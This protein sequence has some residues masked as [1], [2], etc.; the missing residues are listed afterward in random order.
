VSTWTNW[1][2]VVTC[3]PLRVERPRNTDELVAAVRAAPRLRVAGSGHS[4]SEVAATD[5]VLLS[6]EDYATPWSLD[7]GTGTATVPGG[8][9][10]DRVNRFLHE[11]GRALA[12][13]GDIDRQTVAGAVS[14]GTHGTGLGP[15]SLSAQ[16]DG[17]TLVTA[18]GDVLECA[19]DGD[20]DVLRAAQVGLGALGVVAEVRLRTVPAFALRYRKWRATLDE[21]V[22]DLPRRARE[23]R[24][25]EFFWLPGADVVEMKALDATE[26]A[27]RGRRARN[28]DNLLAENAG[29]GLLCALGRRW[30]ARVPDL[31]RRAARLIRE[32][33]GVDWSHRVF[34]SRRWVHFHEMEYAVPLAALPEVVGE[35]RAWLSRDRPPLCIP[36]EV[37]VLAAEDPW[38][39]MAQGRESAFV[40]VHAHRGLDHRPV[41]AGAEEVFRRHAG[42]PHWGK[43]HTRAYAELRPLYPAWDRFQEVRRRLDPRGAFTSPHV[44]RVLGP[45]P[46]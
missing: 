11:R 21:A 20:A 23:H 42:R 40:A 37:R 38:L 27:P 18:A 35:L 25:L 8:A 24:H 29:L 6:L 44:A 33:E 45:A 7:A 15:P 36:I 46:A 43:A 16:V 14:T 4:F 34:C 31:V 39:S 28:L 1:S 12:N 9:R 10:L 32:G 22:S 3:R 41:F 13:L 5:D 19:A 2:G 17:L 26:E 30:P